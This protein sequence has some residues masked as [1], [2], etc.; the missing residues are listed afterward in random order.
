MD[1]ILNDNWDDLGKKV[2]AYVPDEF[3]PSDWEAMEKM[4]NDL[5]AKNGNQINGHFYLKGFAI[6]LLIIAA[7]LFVYLK[8]NSGLEENTTVTSVE[9]NVGQS[10]EGER[11][12]EVVTDLVNNNTE[13]NNSKN[14]E[15]NNGVN[16]LENEEKNNSVEIKNSIAANTGNNFTDKSGENN[17]LNTAAAN[18]E[19]NL[20]ENYGS[21]DLATGDL[22][23]RMAA[24]EKFVSEG[25]PDLAAT[26]PIESINLKEEKEVVI[27]LEPIDLLTT[28][29]LLP[30][31][32]EAEILGAGTESVLPVKNKFS[33]RTRFGVL[34][35]LNNA[36]VDYEAMT[37]SHLPFIGFFANKK[38]S[39]KLE[40]Q[41]EVHLKTVNNY[42]LRQEWENTVFGAGGSI[43]RES[44]VEVY[45]SYVSVDVPLVLKYATSRRIGLLGGVRFSYLGVSQN[46]AS[47]SSFSSTGIIAPELILSENIP[48]QGF[49]NYD[50][51]LILGAEYYL[52]SRWVADLRWNQGFRDITPDNLYNDDAVHL[53][54]D[55][56]FSLR[57]IF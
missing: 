47:I 14:Q 5:P 38:I 57:F 10:N 20:T 41:A 6:G 40:L 31:D 11:K 21:A 28:V 26:G 44:A 9:K 27:D 37:T 36:I 29:E 33:K 4:L 30:L 55:L 15:I 12:L 22:N 42:D 13:K 49:W 19:N 8:I 32:A 46:A 43:S 54:S 1:K 50:L 34:L 25:N 23:L 51:N 56:Q 39:E 35:G 24:E 45:K 52:S 18:E 53:N 17:L 16:T 48:D 3:S 7:A 2:S